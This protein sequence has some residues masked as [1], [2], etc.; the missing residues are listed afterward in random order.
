MT[1][2]AYPLQ[3]PTGYPRTERPISA[4]FNT[5]FAAARDAALREVR[6]LGAKNAVISSNVP[7][8]R[9]GLPYANTQ[10]L[11]DNGVA[12]YFYYNDK[13]LVLACDKWNA[14]AD[15]MQAIRKAVEAIRGLDRWGVSDMLNR[16][17]TG[18]T[19]LP[20]AATKE[21]FQILGV[22]KS[23]TKSEITTAYKMLAHI[24]H[25]D[26]GGSS[27]SFQELNDAYQQGLKQ[28]NP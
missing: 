13:Q 18:F 9:D 10:K 17:F 22:S 2:E 27:E 21:W 7:L 20:N 3:W 28:S 19:A 11:N 15:N 14:P 8:R 4:Q 16:A 23:A 5:S 25:P 1:E 12:L 26:K 6:L 24:M